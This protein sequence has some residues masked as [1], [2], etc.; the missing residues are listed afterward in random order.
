[1]NWCIIIHAYTPVYE[2]EAYVCGGNWFFAKS[3]D[4]YLGC[5]FSNGYEMVAMV[6]T[7]KKRADIRRIEPC[8]D[9]KCGSKEEFG[10]FEV[11]QENLKEMDI[12]WDGDRNIAFA[13]VQY[14]EMRVR[15]RRNFW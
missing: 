6:P 1:M 11:F 3:G 7:R 9:R 4:G 8:C 2:Y 14:G 15:M 12:E 10:S 5:W 13:D